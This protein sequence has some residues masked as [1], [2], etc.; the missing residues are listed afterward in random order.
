MRT[1]GEFLT[2]NVYPTTRGWM[3]STMIRRVGSPTARLVGKA[4]TWELPES[5]GTYEEAL[6]FASERLLQLAAELS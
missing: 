2:V 1:R 3:C 6:R 5:V 4:V